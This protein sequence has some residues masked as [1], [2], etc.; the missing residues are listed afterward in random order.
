MDSDTWNCDLSRASNS[1]RLRSVIKRVNT[2]HVD[3]RS[4]RL[5]PLTLHLRSLTLRLSVLRSIHDRVHR[6]YFPLD[7][8]QAIDK[9]NPAD[10][11][12]IT[13]RIFMSD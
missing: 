2:L 8:V 13:L 10:H 11:F 4:M 6:F 12:S 5:K 7:D 3:L 9:R 1:V